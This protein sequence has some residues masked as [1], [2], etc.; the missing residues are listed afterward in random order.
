[1]F[2][3][4]IVKDDLLHL[5]RKEAFKNKSTCTAKMFL[6]KFINGLM[7]VRKAL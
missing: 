5:H 7:N 2:K 4:S 6:N 1:M 3:L